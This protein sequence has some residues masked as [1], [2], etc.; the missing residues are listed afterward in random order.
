LKTSPI[1]VHGWGSSKNGKL[2]FQLAN[3]KNYDLPKEII[4]LKDIEIY[5][6]AAGPFHTIL[7]T[8]DGKLYSMGNSKD[9][10]LG[11]ETVGGSVVDVALPERIPVRTTAGNVTF[12]RHQTARIEKKEYPLFADFDG[13]TNL[14]PIVSKNDTKIGS[15]EIK[16]VK[17]GENF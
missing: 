16:Q 14:K 8:T 3:G 12:F 6:I 9:G 2:G 13:F 10:K 11:Y 17:C 7:L 5:Q 15:Y 1:T 4:S